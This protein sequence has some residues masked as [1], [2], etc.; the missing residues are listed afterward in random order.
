MCDIFYPS[1]ELPS[2]PTSEQA[3]TKNI[4]LDTHSSLWQTHRG[5]VS[6]SEN[7]CDTEYRIAEYRHSVLFQFGYGVTGIFS[8]LINLFQHELLPLP[9]EWQCPIR[10]DARS[11]LRG[12]F[13][14]RNVNTFH[15]TQV[16]TKYRLVLAMQIFSN[17]W[18]WDEYVVARVNEF[19]GMAHWCVCVRAIDQ[20][21]FTLVLILFFFLSSSLISFLENV[22][23]FFVR[24]AFVHGTGESNERKK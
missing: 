11:H 7:E 8:V 23:C 24:T 15:E 19:G 21:L 3:P 12:F 1:S 2:R 10:N 13:S 6:G 14:R 22:K 20:Q 18:A 9:A 17:T 4:P 16:K 5:R